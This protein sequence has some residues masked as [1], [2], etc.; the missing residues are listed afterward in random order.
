[1]PTS[2][3]V[4]LGPAD[5]PTLITARRHEIRADE[6]PERGGTDIGPEPFE[7]LLASLGVCTAI[8]LRMYARRKGWP[9]DDVQVEAEFDDQRTQG[10]RAIRMALSVTGELS[11]EQQARLLQI[12]NAC[13][14]HKVLTAGVTVETELAS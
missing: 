11:A 7:F 4:T 5:F 9:L 8:T 6:P 12:A 14:V 3:F 1:M 13:P 2:V 10:R